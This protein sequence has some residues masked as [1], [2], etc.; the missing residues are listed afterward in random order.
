MLK[1]QI[2]MSNEQVQQIS[3]MLQKQG[4]TESEMI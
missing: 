3:N 2:K 1:E 4:L